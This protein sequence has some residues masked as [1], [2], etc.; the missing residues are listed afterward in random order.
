[1]RKPGFMSVSHAT[2]EE[3]HTADDD[4]DNMPACIKEEEPADDESLDQ[5]D[6]ACGDDCQQTHDVED[7]ND[8]QDDVACAGKVASKDLHS[9]EDKEDVVVD[10]E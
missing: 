5:H 4:F 9:F 3:R 8:I 1:M 2:D 10:I 7:S 6:R